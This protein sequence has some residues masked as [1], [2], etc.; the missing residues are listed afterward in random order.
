[1]IGDY[2]SGDLAGRI[3]DEE[4]YRGPT[5]AL[6]TF[7]LLSFVIW[8]KINIESVIDAQPLSF[9]QLAQA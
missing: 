9:T 3:Q 6:R 5:G 7:A 8:G 1:L 2:L 4:L